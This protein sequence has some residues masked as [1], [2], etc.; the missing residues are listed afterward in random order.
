MGHNKETTYQRLKR[1][2]HELRQKLFTLATQPYSD[3]AFQIKAEVTTIKD[4]EDAIWAGDS[5]NPSDG[6]L[7]QIAK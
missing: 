3:A 7:K 2:N 6:L 5:S 4:I 1:E